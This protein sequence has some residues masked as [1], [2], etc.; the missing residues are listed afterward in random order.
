MGIGRFAFT[1]ILP[2]M[3]D[4]F[5]LSVSE[6][7]WLAT[8]NYM[9]YL[10]GG[11]IIPATFLPVMAKKIIRAQQDARGPGQSSAANPGAHRSRNAAQARSIRAP[12]SARRSAG[13]AKLPRK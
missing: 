8:A 12:T 6:G 9:G 7:G 2:M 13:K 5:G 10:V 11:Y 4:D 1:P 3:Q